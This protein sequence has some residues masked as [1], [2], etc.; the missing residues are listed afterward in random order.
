[1]DGQVLPSPL[2]VLTYVKA[3]NSVHLRL[4]LKPGHTQLPD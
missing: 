4:F 2:P 3:P 1:M